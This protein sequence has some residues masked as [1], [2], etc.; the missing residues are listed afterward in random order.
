MAANERTLPYRLPIAFQYPRPASRQRIRRTVDL[1]RLLHPP[2]LGPPFRPG[3][4]PIMVRFAGELQPIPYD[5][6]EAIGADYMRLDLPQAADSPLRELAEAAYIFGGWA[7]VDSFL[8]QLR[9]IGLAAQDIPF[10]AA[11]LTKT[12]PAADIIRDMAG[13]ADALGLLPMPSRS[14]TELPSRMLPA[15]GPAGWALELARYLRQQVPASLLPDPVRNQAATARAGRVAVAFE[16]TV[17][18]LRADVL[19]ELERVEEEAQRLALRRLAEAR[20]LIISE[21]WRTLGTIRGTTFEQWEDE[22]FTPLIRHEASTKVLT[23]LTDLVRSLGPAINRAMEAEE[24]LIDKAVDQAAAAAFRAVAAGGGSTDPGE[25][26]IAASSWVRAVYLAP[27]AEPITSLREEA[28][29][30]RNAVLVKI[31]APTQAFPI[32][33][34]FKMQELWDASGQ[35]QGDMAERVYLKL[36]AALKANDNMSERL[37]QAQPIARRGPLRDRDLPEPTLARDYDGS[38]WAYAKLIDE[39]CRSLYLVPGT[40]SSVAVESFMGAV[41]ERKQSDAGVATAISMGEGAL[42]LALAMVCPPAAVAVD[43]LYNLAETVM[44]LSAYRAQSDEFL[45][46]LD[47][48]NAFTEIEPSMLPVVFAASG[49]VLSVI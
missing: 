10:C 3:V 33:R 35:W 23:A 31:A 14:A 24:A 49:I 42:S 44:S 30:A 1:D 6:A 46:T 21:G 32:L 17:A 13:P 38:V 29:A 2:S 26:M 11:M 37:K 22:H 12:P 43:L 15:S 48:A 40:L 20:T 47:P 7:R 19:A 36:W 25:F 5:P 8:W 18:K 34:R 39:A 27:D 45:C 28:E 4:E 16:H 9:W 41:A